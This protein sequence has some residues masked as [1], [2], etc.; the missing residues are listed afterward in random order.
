MA[1]LDKIFTPLVPPPVGYCFIVNFLIQGVAPLLVPRDMCF[2][3]VSGFSVSMSPYS[4]EEGGQNLY[5]I[6]LPSRFK[7]ENLVLKRGLAVL[8]GL[9]LQFQAA[10]T[11]YEFKHV[12]VLVTLMNESGVP[13]NSWLFVNAFPVKWSSTDL[14]AEENKIVIETLELAYERFQRITL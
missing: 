7:Y 6:R 13:V 1:V 8:S 14:N 11:F 2:Q 10:M 5:D 3:S 12:N 4:F 9:T